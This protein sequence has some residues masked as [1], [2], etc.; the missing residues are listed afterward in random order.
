VIL[1][2]MPFLLS[3]GRCLSSKDGWAS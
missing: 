1:V 3:G 2:M